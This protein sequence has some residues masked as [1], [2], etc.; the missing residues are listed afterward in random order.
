M[1]LAIPMK[2][3]ETRNDGTGVVEL[4]GSRRE[5]NLS[6]LADPQIGDYVIVHAGFAI[7]KLDEED[8]NERIALFDELATSAGNVKTRKE[9]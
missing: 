2:I 7:E 3:V 4:D 6:L 8:A 1:C 9:V 5:A